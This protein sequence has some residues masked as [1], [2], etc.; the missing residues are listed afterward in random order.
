MFV[1]PVN[2]CFEFTQLN[3]IFEHLDYGVAVVLRLARCYAPFVLQLLTA[4]TSILCV[5]YRL[6]VQYNIPCLFCPENSYTQ[7]QALVYRLSR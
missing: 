5:N 1:P 3:A 4:R 6:G 2:V 7:R